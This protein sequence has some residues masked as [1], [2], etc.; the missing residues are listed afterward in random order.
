MSED[1]NISGEPGNDVHLNP[2]AGGS[3]VLDPGT[4]TQTRTF[5]GRDNGYL[6][7]P[8]KGPP[9]APINGDVWTTPAGMFT[10]ISGTTVGPL[11]TGGTGGGGGEQGPPG[12]A[13]PT[14]PQGPPGATGPAGP[15]G[16]ASSV[17]GP[18]GPMGPQGP[19]G[20][21][22]A[23]ST[24]P[25][26][27][28]PPGATGAQGPKGDPG[29][30]STVPGPAGPTGPKG[31]TGAQGA[32]GPQGVEGP[33]GVAGTGIT[34]QGSVATSGDLPASGNTQ[35]DA[36]IVQADDSL[37]IWD[38]TAWVSG[39]SIQGPP[40]SQGP[41]GPQGVAGPQG[42]QGVPG[43][44]GPQGD[45]G[46]QGPIG[47]AGP[48]GTGAGAA[49]G[50]SAHKSA[51]QTVTSA[52][53]TK[54][55]FATTGYNNG[56]FF[57]TS[58]SRWTPP[59]GETTFVASAFATGLAIG[60]NLFIAIYKNGTLFKFATSNTTDGFAH[61]VCNDNAGGTDYYEAWI[62]GQAIGA[63]FIV[64]TGSNDGIYF[65]GFQAK[66]PPGPAGP[67]GADG[68]ND[69]DK[70]D[71]TASGG[72]TVW[73]IDNNAVTYAK[74]QDISASGRV[75]ARKS[76]GAGDTEEA[77]L[78]EILDFI[79]SAARGDILF[80]GNT[81]WQRLPAGTDGGVL[82]THGV[83]ADPT[84][85]AP[86]AG[87]GGKQTIWVPAGAIVSRA[88]NG[89]APG[90]METTTNKNMVRT[91]DYDGATQEFAQFEIAMPKSWD[92]GTLTFIPIWSHAATTTNFGVQWALQA[93]ARSDGD[94][95]DAAFGTEQT[96]TDTGG[97][98][99]VQYTAPESAAIT[100][101]GS[102]VENDVVLFQIK[103]N[104]AAAADTLAVDARL[105]GVKIF[106]TTNA[107]SDA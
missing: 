107:G 68:V 80:R 99:N 38:G 97:T 37:W 55:A 17:P 10:R 14:G 81:G 15:A 4:G 82:T 16:P 78:S 3:L 25:G 26:P 86:T 74:L 29:A 5:V 96:S 20:D 105:H 84:W 70:G 30:A 85:T 59:A 46:P 33:Q 87:G 1:F 28:G 53:W 19:K 11:G 63:S 102:P 79:G 65:Q 54:L 58:S 44:T 77:T 48:T 60:S 6:N 88:S 101:G 22:G 2:G 92:E 35:G 39:G 106:Y 76:A 73:T 42:P 90:T 98:T 95:I 69:G 45:T 50:F 71:I 67:P 34:M 100:I 13:G 40:G 41:Q 103:R 31:D 62:N 24:V 12:P 23:A 89:A 43:S 94:A 8:H 52:T 83:G 32:Q 21:T 9:P 36:Y 93:L 47:P 57:N 51:D 27:A 49:T 104:P 7:L 91:L 64:P 75:L 18:A 72:G 56:N 66:G 61:I